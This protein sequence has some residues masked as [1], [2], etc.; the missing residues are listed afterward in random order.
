MSFTRNTTVQ[1]IPDIPCIP[2]F[3]FT[4]TKA[5]DITSKKEKKN[6]LRL[7]L[8]PILFLPSPQSVFAAQHSNVIK[9]S[10]ITRRTIRK[11]QQMKLIEGDVVKIILVV[12]VVTVHEYKEE[13][14]FSS[15]GSTVLYDTPDVH[16]VT[17]FTTRNVEPELPI[18][19]EQAAVIEIKAGWCDMCCPSCVYKPIKRQSQSLCVK[20]NKNTLVKAARYRVK[21]EVQSESNSATFI[22]FDYEAHRFFGI[23]ANEIFDKTG[24]NNTSLP[25]QLLEIVGTT[26]EFQEKDLPLHKDESSSFITTSSESYQPSPDANQIGNPEESYGAVKG[27]D[28]SANKLKRKMPLE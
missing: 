11:E 9:T 3:K 7:I 22:I 4:F 6:P 1:H 21:L 13:L 26:K 25:E 8:H 12:T 17:A 14:S 5:S 2:T 27:P 24:Q 28:S 10:N 16:A 18:F 15:S 23:S 20:C 19:V